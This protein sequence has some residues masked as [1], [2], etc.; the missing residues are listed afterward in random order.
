MRTKR[1]GSDRARPPPPPMPA[2]GARRSTRVFLPRAHKQAPRSPEPARV[3]RSAK[4]LAIS[5]NHSHWLGWEQR[6]ASTS[7]DDDDDDG[8]KPRTPQ[9]EPSPDRPMSPRSF[10][11]VYRRKRRQRPPPEPE[12]LANGDGDDGSDRR[13]GLVFTRKHKR[14][15]LAPF[16]LCSSSRELAST[17]GLLE[18]AHFLG[19]AVGSRSAVLVVLVDASSP[20]SS[21]RFS[22]LLLP[23]LLWL[24]RRQ[25]SHVRSLASFL[26]ASPAVA[27][28]FASHGVHFIRL[29]RQRASAL[30][31][32]P[33]VN[34]GWCEL[35]GAGP[36]R[37][38]VLSVNFSAFPSYFQ[39]LHS[40]TALRFIYLPA[41]IRRAMG[42][43][44][45]AE[46]ESYS[47]DH[48]EVDSGSPSTGDAT[49]AVGSY[50]AVQ[51]YVP[52]EQAPGVVLHGLRLKKH[53]RKRSSMRHP[54]SRRR[55]L[56]VRFSDKEIGVK[57][58]TVTS[59]TELQNPPLTGG[60]E[61]SEEPV[62][63]KPAME[64]SLDLLD[65]MDDSD[66]STPMGPSGKQKRSF[67]KS[68]VDRTS[69]RPALSEVRQ[70]I[71]TFR[72]KANLLI[73]QADRCWRE[74]GA[75]VMLELSN[76]NGWCVAV[77]L[78]GVTRVSL[79]PSE[80]RFYV[81][82][83]HTHAYVW[84]VEDGWKLEFP[85]KWDW[86]LF[87]EL[88]IEGRERNSQGKII[89][90]PGVHEVSDGMGGTVADPFSRPVTDY[91]RTADDEVARA[92]S[93]DSAYDMDSEDEEW[94]IQL[95]HGPSDRRR[96]R[97]N[98]ISYEDF[99]KLIT[100]FEKDAYNNPEEANDVDQL[101]SRHPALGKG[102]NVLA[103]YGYWTNKRDKKGTPLLRI[104]Q[105][106]PA[107]RRGRPSQKSS[108][109]KK[110]SVKRPQRSQP[111]R[112]KPGFFLQGG[113]GEALQ[114][115]VEADRAAKQA[116]DKAIQL[117]SRAQALMERANLAA[118]KSVMAVRI[119]DAASVSE[120][121]RDVVWRSL[122]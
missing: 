75:E 33:T 23:V 110:R 84:A 94:L 85:D 50:G 25:R 13:F 14:A 53:Q 1:A 26:L 106:A 96:T 15:K 105:G 122:D 2:V 93:R 67:F 40:A 103:I 42:L 34:C 70:N 115:V 46:E 20:G 104:F 114:R 121:C 102:D 27:T 19:G 81:V 109:K 98:Q 73:I 39:G 59:Q 55:R 35:R 101:L 45:G 12:D 66:V 7:D 60:P 24:R 22:R 68:P 43:A 32:R 100:L 10:G 118:Y 86:L 74:E 38:P 29:Q 119:A 48:P 52:L 30:L 87:K 47:R 64:I 51:D 28:A 99:E 89:P 5:S 92:L 11:A 49:P 62:Q 97:L 3:T 78:H 6:A 91:I 79:K 58:G 63:P 41:V 112:G 44:G 120:R 21:S 77:K 76:S 72:C 31:Q 8:P 54:L 113:E 71:D 56:T 80:Q 17:V 116:V 16:G 108:V 18:D 111:G 90:I 82:N 69:E 37:Q 61:V 83:R 95:K 4:R 117:R 36:S 107:V 88:H 57:E 9:R 65:N